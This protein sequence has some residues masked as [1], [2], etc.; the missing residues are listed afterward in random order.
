MS[1]PYIGEIRL[2][3]FNF[4][5]VGWALCAGQLVS[6]SQND[7][8]F[9]LL[10]TTYGGDGIQT[11]ALPDLRGRAPIHAGQGP[12]LTNRIQGEQLGSE[13]VT[14][15]SNQMPAH[16]HA[17]RAQSAAGAASKPQNAVWAGSSAGDT[18]YKAALATPTTLNPQ[19]LPSAGSNQAHE[20]REPLLV[21][22][23]IIALYGI[24]PSRG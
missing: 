19:A 7:A 18:P 6:I 2:V 4:A 3:G 13:S 17:A 10:G 20:N 14:L 22:N 15:T 11:F 1:Q 21:M 16:N 5:P 8:L 24:F 9:A 12:G 23:Y